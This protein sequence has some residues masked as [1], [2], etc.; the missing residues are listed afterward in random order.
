MLL[1][2]ECRESASVQLLGKYEVGACATC[3]AHT[4]KRWRHSKVLR[5]MEAGTSRSAR[6]T[7]RKFFCESVNVAYVGP[8]PFGEEQGARGLLL[9]FGEV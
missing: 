3:C 8:F 5:S 4:C 6:D 7:M 2:C 9:R 1:M